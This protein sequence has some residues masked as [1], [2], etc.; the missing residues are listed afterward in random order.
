MIVTEVKLQQLAL[1]STFHTCVFA[2]TQLAIIIYFHKL[3]R[4]EAATA[5]PFDTLSV[6]VPNC[7]PTIVQLEKFC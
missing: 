7:P 5:W 4:T 6:A 2:F 3:A 1:S